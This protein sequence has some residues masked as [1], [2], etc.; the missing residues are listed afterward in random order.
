[1]TKRRILTEMKATDRPETVF[2]NGK[3]V[4]LDASDGIASA[5]ALKGGLIAAVGSNEE[6]KRIAGSGARLIDLK[7]KT[8]LPGFI[9]AHTHLGPASFS[10]RYYVDARCPPN[11]SIGDILDRIRQRAVD[12]PEG[13]WIIA[14]MNVFTDLK[15]AEKR[16]PTKQEL[17]SVAPKHP[18]LILASAHTQIVNTCALK[19]A[20]VTHKTPDPAGGKIERDAASGEATGLLREC[21]KILP[22]PP[23]SCDRIKESLKEMVPE[24]WVKQ[25]FTTACTFVDSME[26][27]CYQ[28]LLNEGSLPLRIH[29][30]PLDDLKRH[31]FLEGMF[32]LGIRPGFGNDWLKIGAVK[33]Y[34]DGAFKGLSAATYGPYLN[35]DTDHYCGL[36]RRDPSTLN[37]LVL[38]AHD[39]GVQICIHAIGEKAQDLA[40]DAYEKALEKNPRP[41]RHRIEHLGNI[42]THPERIRRAR[43]M[44][45]LP[46]TTTQWLYAYG[47]FIELYLGPERKKHSFVL[48]SM[49]DAGLRPAN[50]SDCRGAEPLSINP[51]FNI[52]CAV[53]RQ[54]FF[55]NRLLP[56]EAISV[57]EGLRLYTTSASYAG[58]EEDLK[59]SIEPGKLA[60]MIVIDRDILAI[61][62]NQIKDIKVEMTVLDGK[63]V[64]QR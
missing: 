48:R 60:D 5:V 1:M 32:S 36:F 64:Y 7:G 53:T 47:D 55:G 54:T 37:D 50:G 56:E 45:I 33:I 41:H 18:V 52:W 30:M 27:R 26:M 51:F 25:G 28:D 34:T 4:T 35:I 2:F 63:I 13:E 59:G 6:V 42:M 40:L 23:V 10:F 16:F 15:L 11:R 12:L 22:I 9:D 61:P 43:A 21:R 24:Y 44:E 20:G 17:D 58:F 19:L 38:R 29:A 39:A 8:M 62:E 14:N 31:E 57:K 46:I 3:I 49:L